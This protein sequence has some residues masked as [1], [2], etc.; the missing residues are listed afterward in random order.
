[1]NDDYENV[2]WNVHATSDAYTPHVEGDDPLSAFSNSNG[3]QNNNNTHFGPMKGFVSTNGHFDDLS[4]SPPLPS[5]PSFMPTVMNGSKSTTATSPPL[6]PTAMTNGIKKEITVTTPSSSSSIPDTP[7]SS[8]AHHTYKSKS[9]YSAPS[10]PRESFVAKPMVISVADP[11]KHSDAQ[12]TYITYLVTTTTT[13]DTFVSSHPRSVRRRFQDFVWLH[14]ALLLEYPASIVPPL[15]DKHRLEY[16]KGDRFSSEFIDRRR[17]SLQWFLNRISRHP[18][19]QRS[20]SVRVF[21]ESG[22][23]R[24]DKRMQSRKVPPAASVLDTLS[25]TLLN[26]FT[27]IKKPDERFVDMKETVDKLE[28][29]LDTVERLYSR[30]G[31]RQKDLQQDYAS[32]S[33]SIQGLSTLET[34]ISKQ[35]QGFADTTS[36]YAKAMDEMNHDEDLLFLNDVHELL[37]YCHAAKVTLRAR[38]QKQV[39]FE[40]LSAYFHRTTQERERTLHPGR[41]LDG[42]LNISEIVTDKINEVRGIDMQH[43]RREKLVRL[44]RKIKELESEVA[45][46]ND[47]SNAFNDQVIKEYEVFQQAKT[48]EIKQGLVAYA[49]SHIKFYETGVSIWESILPTLESIHIDDG[50]GDEEEVAEESSTTS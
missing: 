5:S 39:D 11:Q 32:F 44:E 19:L 49:D 47:V 22:D 50:D 23:F 41:H 42:G 18:E 29:N 48:E 20:Q 17:M 4:S 28:D 10:P 40:E 36:K 25:D 26:A 45:H 9:P 2:E 1:M 15:P 31:K 46:A 3:Y 14:N 35:L 16:I 12:G 21:L 33:Q 8:T 38:D 7:K 6:P 30:I 37:A 13:L 24:N 34:G 43:A 27:K